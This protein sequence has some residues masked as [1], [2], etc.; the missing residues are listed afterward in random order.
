MRKM[1][2]NNACRIIGQTRHEIAMINGIATKSK[3]II[4]PFLLQRQ[5]LLQLHSN[6]K[7]SKII[8]F[9][10]QGFS[11]LGEYDGRDQKLY[12]VVCHM[13]G[14]SADMA[15]RESSPL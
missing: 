9:S 12:R 4:I 10:R 1:K 7:R 6:H 3:R 2:W 5:T 15:T 13:L 11:V 8:R 14:I